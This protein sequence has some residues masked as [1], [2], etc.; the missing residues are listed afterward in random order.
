MNLTLT[1]ENKISKAFKEHWSAA[2]VII[3][4]VLVFKDFSSKEDDVFIDPN[5]TEL[6]FRRHLYL[7]TIKSKGTYCL[8]TNNGI[9][10][11]V[12]SGREDNSFLLSLENSLV[13]LM[14]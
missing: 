5:S 10:N 13:Q 9:R 7:I 4:E 3:K 6:R 14:I 8:Y 12:G 1:E 11:T 2:F